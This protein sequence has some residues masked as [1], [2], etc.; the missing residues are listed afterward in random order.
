M[1]IF[2]LRLHLPY[3]RCIQYKIVSLMRLLK[4]GMFLRHF[5]IRCSTWGPWIPKPK[6][7]GGMKEHAYLSCCHSVLVRVK[8][9]SRKNKSDHG[10]KNIHLRCMVQCEIARLS[11]FNGSVSFRIFTTNLQ[12][13]LYKN[14]WMM[15]NSI[16]MSSHSYKKP[17]ITQIEDNEVHAFLEISKHKMIDL[18][19][20][21]R[22][23]N[24][25]NNVL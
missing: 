16:Q 20:I 17:L 12:S 10:L 24:K 15:H 25:W 11:T 23:L 8:L 18:I 2:E 19:F 21:M 13:S 7:A 14:S 1:D 3:G 9:P 5:L 22:W 4:S 6:F